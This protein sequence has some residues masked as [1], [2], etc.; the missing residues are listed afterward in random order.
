MHRDQ[1]IKGQ[2][3]PKIDML[4]REASTFTSG[5]SMSSSV[6]IAL[7]GQIPLPRSCVPLSTKVLTLPA[8]HCSPAKRCGGSNE[9]SPPRLSKVRRLRSGK[10]G[11]H[12]AIWLRTETHFR[13][14]FA[15]SS[16]LSYSSTHRI[17]EKPFAV[18][19]PEACAV[20]RLW[21]TC[22]GTVCNAASRR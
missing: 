7:C 11:E 17:S 5:T 6:T 20:D 22:G 3:A 12:K 4:E 13:S 16:S 15:A 19:F 1:I 10:R 8:T 18:A 9:C 14:F 2:A 21:R